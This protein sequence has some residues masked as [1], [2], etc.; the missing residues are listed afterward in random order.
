VIFLG[1]GISYRE[2]LARQAE[3]AKAKKETK[4]PKSP[5]GASKK[6]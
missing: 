6:K 4:K 3:Q 5:K 2:K 1:K